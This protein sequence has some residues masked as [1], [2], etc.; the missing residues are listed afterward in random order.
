MTEHPLTVDE[1]GIANIIWIDHATP[2]VEAIE[3]PRRFKTS[4]TSSKDKMALY[5]IYSNNET[6]TTSPQH[7]HSYTEKGNTFPL[8]T[9]SYTETET[10][11]PGHEDS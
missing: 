8:F 2:V 9:D 7:Q 3:H 11:F 1:N 4:K 6:E 10:T 5:E